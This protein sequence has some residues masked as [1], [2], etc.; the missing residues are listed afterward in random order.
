[1][2]EHALITGVSGFIG[3]NLLDHLLETT[4]WQ[5]TGV[6]NLS[7]G[8]KENIAHNLDNGRFTFLE[9]DVTE[10]GSLKDYSKVFHMA[11]LP[12]IQPSFELIKDHVEANLVAAVHLIELMV[13]E[14]HYPRFVYS[15]SSAAYGTPKNTPT[16]EEEP[17]D[18]LSPYAYQ[19]YE[20]EVYLRLIATRYPLNFVILRYFNVYGPRSF[21]PAN[22]FNAYSSVVGIF[23]YAH[24][25]GNTL[26]VTGDG[27]QQRDFI[28]VKDIAN[29]NYHASI[30]E[31]IVN[32]VFN[33]GYGDTISVIDLAKLISDD[34]DFIPAREGEA[35][36][37]HADNAKARKV[38]GWTPQISLDAFLNQP[39]ES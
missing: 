9:Q 31:G 29:A 23:Q 20:V 21:N 15:G 22:P 38:L 1:M 25:Q 3:S 37:T 2:S 6:D 35:D 18:C 17:I 30:K 8:Q 19:K 39:Q 16:S 36:I 14:E 10:I 5:I 34:I 27:S 32:D 11:A 12:R 33:I 7:T 26:H 28:H 4:N 13:K 24:Q